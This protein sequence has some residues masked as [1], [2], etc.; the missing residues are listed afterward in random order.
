M[1][2][3]AAIALTIPI[4]WVG[5]V[6]SGRL[7]VDRLWSFLLPILGWLVLIF[8]NL[9]VFLPGLPPPALFLPWPCCRALPFVVGHG[10]NR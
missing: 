10:A 7:R 6:L 9:V 1:S 3:H 8:I 5:P 4:L 2:R